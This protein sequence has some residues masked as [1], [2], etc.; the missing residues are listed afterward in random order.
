MMLIFGWA[1]VTVAVVGLCSSVVL[2]IKK[3]EPLYMT[4]AKI[5]AGLLGIGG[6]ILAIAS[7]GG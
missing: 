4:T 2:E 7:L 6:V 5:S 3:H 1:I